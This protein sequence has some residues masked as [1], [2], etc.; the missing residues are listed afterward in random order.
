MG[1]ILLK[2]ALIFSKFLVSVID[3]DPK[4]KDCISFQKDFFLRNLNSQLVYVNIF[5]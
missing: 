4:E 5:S 2:D 1:A 3:E